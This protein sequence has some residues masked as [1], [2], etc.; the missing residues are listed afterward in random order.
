MRVSFKRF[1]AM[2]KS[3]GVLSREAADF[4]TELGKERV[5]SISHSADQSTGV[6]IVWYWGKPESCFHCGYDVRASEERCPECGKA[7]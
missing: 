7:L 4:A 3:W 1:E 5:I 2:M 6:I